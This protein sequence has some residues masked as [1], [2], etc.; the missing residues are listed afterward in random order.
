MLQGV[1]VP[2]VSRS[3]IMGCSQNSQP[4]CQTCWLKARTK[5]AGFAEFP[6]VCFRCSSD[7][8]VPIQS[9]W[10]K[11]LHP[12]RVLALWCWQ[13]W[14]ELQPFCTVCLKMKSFGGF[15]FPCQVHLLAVLWVIEGGE[16]K[17][18]PGCSLWVFISAFLRKREDILRNIASPVWEELAHRTVLCSFS[19]FFLD[20]PKFLIWIRPNFTDGKCKNNFFCQFEFT[21]A[22][23]LWMT[24]KDRNLVFLYTC[25]LEICY[26][27]TPVNNP[28]CVF[29]LLP[30]CVQV[31]VPSLL[32]P[33]PHSSLCCFFHPCSSLIP[34]SERLNKNAK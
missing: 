21:D 13:H 4:Q 8:P 2:V 1:T 7:A 20:L 14:A 11:S 5:P 3:G 6:A 25:L 31:P 34:F 10:H 15:V 27:S 28:S 16:G 17:E 29:L 9:R 22:A 24:G 19:F 26:F 30:P 23:L 32:S 12:F 33:V 18:E